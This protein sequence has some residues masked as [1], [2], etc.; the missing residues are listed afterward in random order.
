MLTT[1]ALALVLQ[2][3]ERPVASSAAYAACAA[4]AVSMYDER[5]CLAAEVER[6]RGEVTAAVLETGIDAESHALWR[7]LI[8]H[9]CQGEYDLAGGSNSADMR[10]DACLI[11][12]HAERVSYLRRRG[13]W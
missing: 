13:V 9:D 8:E 10:R 3:A 6:W 1:L 5:R 12:L 4:D 2:A 11:E 7:Q